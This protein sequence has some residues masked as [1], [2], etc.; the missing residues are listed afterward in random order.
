[1]P[2]TGELTFRE[3]WGVIV[4]RRKIVLACIVAFALVALLYLH[5]ATYRYTASLTVAATQQDNT[6]MLSSMSGLASIAGI[7]IPGS[8]VV[9]PFTLYREG[10]HSRQVATTLAA[11][12]ELMTV[13][14]ADQ[15][16]ADAGKWQIGRESCRER[17]GHKVE[18]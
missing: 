6:N 15:W 5:T 8:E 13:D 17:G 11:K 16:A 4:A 9:S 3:F 12:P 18:T 10:L 2:E 7:D 1:M 14:F